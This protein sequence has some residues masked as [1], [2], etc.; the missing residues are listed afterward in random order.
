[1][2]TDP[3]ILAMVIAAIVGFVVA[4]P[5]YLIVYRKKIGEWFSARRK[6][7]KGTGEL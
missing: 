5:T 6:D 7:K 4:I 3:G 2:Y 1:M